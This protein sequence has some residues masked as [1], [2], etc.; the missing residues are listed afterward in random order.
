MSTNLAILG[1]VRQN[2]YQ[3]SAAPDQYVVLSSDSPQVV[4]SSLKFWNG[5]RTFDLLGLPRSPYYEHSWR[6]IPRRQLIRVITECQK[7][8]AA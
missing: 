6:Q 8:V 3:A 5:T 4:Q 7:S 2:W 1:A